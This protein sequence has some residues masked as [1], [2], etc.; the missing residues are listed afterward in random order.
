MNGLSFSDNDPISP[1]DTLAWP[2][3]SSSISAQL[4]HRLFRGVSL[5]PTDK[6]T[7]LFRSLPPEIIER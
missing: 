7:V 4:D 6:S 1:L 2:T 5:Q 3:I